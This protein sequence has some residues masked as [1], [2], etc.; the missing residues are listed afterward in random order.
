MLLNHTG[1]LIWWEMFDSF[2]FGIKKQLKSCTRPLKSVIQNMRHM[3][4]S[5]PHTDTRKTRLQVI[6]SQR[7]NGNYHLSI[8]LHNIKIFLVLIMLP[9]FYLLARTCFNL[10]KSNLRSEY[11]ISVFSLGWWKRF[12]KIHTTTIK[13]RNR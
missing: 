7:E 12:R 5:T 9:E 11:R 6:K 3:K 10:A 2:D 8:F 13:K 4:I 1:A